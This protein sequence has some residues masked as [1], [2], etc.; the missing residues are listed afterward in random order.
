MRASICTLPQAPQMIEA[1]LQGQAEPSFILMHFAL[2]QYVKY[3]VS[4]IPGAWQTL[5]LCEK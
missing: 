1:G 2:C 3:R 5:A 4:N